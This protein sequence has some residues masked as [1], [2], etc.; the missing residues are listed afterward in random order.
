MRGVVN[1]LL[2]L[3]LAGAPADAGGPEKNTDDVPWGE[4]V[5]GLQCRAWVDDPRP[6]LGAE[7]KVHFELWNAGQSMLRVLKW[8]PHHAH[9]EWLDREAACWCENKSP[10]MGGRIGRDGFAA[11]QPGE[12]RRAGCSSRVLRSEHAEAR[13]ERARLQVVYFIYP[14]VTRRY[15]DAWGPKPGDSTPRSVRSNVIEVALEPRL[16]GEKYSIPCCRYP[17]YSLGDAWTMADL[18]AHVRPMDEVMPQEISKPGYSKTDESLKLLRRTDVRL[19]VLEAIKGDAALQRIVGDYVTDPVYE[20]PIGAGEEVVA[21]LTQLTGAEGENWL[22]FKAVR[23]QELDAKAIEAL[24]ARTPGEW[25]EAY[26]GLKCRLL[27]PGVAVP[28]DKSLRFEVH[29]RFDPSTAVSQVEYLNRHEEDSGA[30]MIHL[31]SA[32]TGKVY[33]RQQERI[34]GP[35]VSPT[36]RDR[37]RL[38]SDPLRPVRTA[39]R[40]LSSEG[41]LIPPGDY[42]AWPPMNDQPVSS[43]EDGIHGWRRP[44]LGRSRLGRW[45]FGLPRPRCVCR[46][47]KCRHSSSWHGPPGVLR[48]ATVMPG[49]RS[50]GLSGGRATSLARGLELVSTMG[51]SCSLSDSAWAAAP[52]GELARASLAG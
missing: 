4:E 25:G 39:V 27:G 12:N 42:R 20:R 29:L 14:E 3:A 22:L 16:P 24:R 43:S 47:A 40:L 37:C 26:R 35:E 21:F 30:V 44:G 18:V 33:A 1:A 41:E 6:R 10:Y 13:G 48:W 36:M 34:R 49:R 32:G 52:R 28:Q 38:R 5:D 17:G 31:R 51:T 2:L 7:L 11:L 8:R 50:S 45:G 19:E 23:P 9:I 46:N 15:P